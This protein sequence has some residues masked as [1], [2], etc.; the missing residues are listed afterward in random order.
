MISYGKRSI[1]RVL[2]CL[3]GVGMVAAISM[4]GGGGASAAAAVTLDTYRVVAIQ[5]GQ[6]QIV[7]VAHP[8]TVTFAKPVH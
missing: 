2:G 5:P 7:G 1:G 6:G 3:L 8:V 4:A